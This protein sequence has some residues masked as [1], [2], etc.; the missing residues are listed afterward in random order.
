MSRSHYK[1]ALANTLGWPTYVFPVNQV[2][3]PYCLLT[4][5]IYHFNYD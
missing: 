4:L 2:T 3:A 1:F 5:W